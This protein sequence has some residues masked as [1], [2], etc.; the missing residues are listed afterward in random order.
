[1]QVLF[2]GAELLLYKSI[3][4]ILTRMRIDKYLNK[5]LLVAAPTLEDPIFE[6]SV[7][8]LHEHSSDGALG[9]I[10][11]QPLSL[12]LKK[13]L[14]H[15]GI[16]TNIPEVAE[17]EVLMGGPVGQENGFVLHHDPKN[18]NELTINSSKEI[19]ELLSNKQDNSPFLI[20]LG[21]SSWQSGQLENELM[22]DNWFIAP[23]NDQILF[24]L[25]Y[26][27]R[28]YAAGELIGIDFNNFSG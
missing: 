12:K 6:H 19:L 9:I 28:W 5:N 15:L 14:N 3:P 8:F 17:H 27:Q 1:M 24:D 26:E 25:P 23:Y 20:T 11:N 16:N 10:I 22:N 4:T 21:Y 2:R 13:I 18:N 7:V